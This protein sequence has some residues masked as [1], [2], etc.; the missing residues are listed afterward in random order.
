MQYWGVLGFTGPGSS[1][2]VCVPLHE[3]VHLG[4]HLVYDGH[5]VIQD[6]LGVVHRWVHEIPGE[7]KKDLKRIPS[8]HEVSE[9]S[10]GEEAR[11]EINVLVIISSAGRVAS[12]PR[13]FS[14]FGL[15]PSPLTGAQ[16]SGIQRF[17]SKIWDPDFRCGAG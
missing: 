5:Q 17:G 2:L 1:N 13:T 4:V 10:S 14:V 15:V 8:S 11:R 12:S 7:K 9:L 16:R 6:V 3:V